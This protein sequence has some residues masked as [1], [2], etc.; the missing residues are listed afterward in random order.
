MGLV[1]STL[2]ILAGALTVATVVRL[3][4]YARQ[5]EIHIMQLVGA[6][7][8]YLRGPFVAEGII[9]GGLGALVALVALVAA[10]LA[11]RVSYGAALAGLMAPA[12]P[13]FLPVSVCAWL[14]LGGMAVGC[15]GGAIAA[16]AVR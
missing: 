14:V 9:Q 10:S 12:T 4:L 11:I 16:R 8:S 1:P 2:L 7:L 6:P 3:A 15:A 13:G 5:D